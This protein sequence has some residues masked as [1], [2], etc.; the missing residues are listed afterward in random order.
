[1]KRKS[2]N[3]GQFTHCQKRRWTNVDP[4]TSIPSLVL[5]RVDNV[6][7]YYYVYCYGLGVGEWEGGGGIVGNGPTCM[8]TDIVSHPQP[9]KKVGD[10]YYFGDWWMAC[11]I[12]GET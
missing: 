7:V 9:P 10:I 2:A 12:P 3:I 11:F 6:H 4:A 8:A 5:S 1:M